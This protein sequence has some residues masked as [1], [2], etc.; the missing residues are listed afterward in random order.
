MKQQK[1][2]KLLQM[3]LN[4][5]SQ[6]RIYKFRHVDHIEEES[7][8]VVMSTFSS[9]ATMTQKMNYKKF[10]ESF[11]NWFINLKNKSS[12][13]KGW[14]QIGLPKQAHKPIWESVRLLKHFVELT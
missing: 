3:L 11:K 7:L 5:Y 14:E 13:T 4:N 1:Y 9:L 10:K 8:N 2:G 6:T 12:C